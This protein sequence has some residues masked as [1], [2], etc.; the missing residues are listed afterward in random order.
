M[1][2]LG[3]GGYSLLGL[4]IHGVNYTKDDGSKVFG[5][6]IPVLFENM[7]D[8]IITGRDEI[9]YP[10]VFADIQVNESAS[11]G[12][13]TIKLSWRGAQFGQLKIQGLKS[14]EPTSDGANAEASQT[15]RPGPGP[16]PPPPEQGHLVYRYVPAVGEP[17]KADAEYAVLYPYPA[18]PEGSQKLETTSATVGFQALD[19]QRLPT[20]HHISKTLAAMP[21]YSTEKAEM[22]KGSHVDDLSAA[23]RI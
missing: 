6:Y 7:A 9:G 14:S 3:S 8:P 22:V 2:W 1:A 18:E 10:K 12:D 5:T 11:A 17:G 19:W 13:Y 15:A 21:V 20:L 16:P 23:V 4:Y